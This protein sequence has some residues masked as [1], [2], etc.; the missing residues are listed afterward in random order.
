MQLTCP[1]CQRKHTRLT[2]FWEHVMR[3][4]SDI[5]ELEL[6]MRQVEL[7]NASQER[8]ERETATLAAVS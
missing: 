8:R 3:Q 5:V 4:H 6:D 7:L 1:L 2:T